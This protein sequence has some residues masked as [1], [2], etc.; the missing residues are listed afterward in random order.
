MVYMR[1][2]PRLPFE[3]ARAY[4]RRLGLRCSREFD[5]WATSSAR[6]RNIPSRP[7][8]YY[9]EEYRGMADFLGVRKPAP[10]RLRQ[11]QLPLDR[12]AAG[13]PR[14]G[15]MVE[16]PCLFGASEK[17]RC[18]EPWVVD[19]QR[20]MPEIGQSVSQ[21][22]FTSE[23][24]CAWVV[25]QL[26]EICPNLKLEKAPFQSRASFFYQFA[27]QGTEDQTNDVWL[28]LKVCFA[29]TTA[30]ASPRTQ[31]FRFNYNKG[32]IDGLPGPGIALIALQ[33]GSVAFRTGDSATSSSGTIRS[34][35]IRT[36][37]SNK[38]DRLQTSAAECGQFA[39]ENSGEPPAKRTDKSSGRERVAIF[40]QDKQMF[41]IR[42]LADT[43]ASC[44]RDLSGVHARP[45]VDWLVDLAASDR[46]NRRAMLITHL[47]HIF[48]NK[49]GKRVTFESTVGKGCD[50]YIDGKPTLHRLL[51]KV[52]DQKRRGRCVTHYR[53]KLTTTCNRKF[54]LA[55]EFVGAG[56]REIPLSQ[57]VAPKFV[58][59][60]R[61]ENSVPGALT[62]IW[63]FPR[64]MFASCLI[65]EG[66][67]TTGRTDL[68]LFTPECRPT[69]RQ[70]QRAQA[71]QMPY[72]IPVANG[73]ISDVD[74]ERARAILD[75]EFQ[76]QLYPAFVQ[77]CDEGNIAGKD[78]NGRFGEEA[79][80]RF[81]CI[82]QQRAP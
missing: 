16:S 56:Y 80:L 35:A 32:D 60:L 79:E 26:S 48:Y 53:I 18:E 19:R 41:P 37:T 81:S 49:L 10:W 73:R 65:V 29:S 12:S 68:P 74:F 47:H 43:L 59:A 39:N 14:A 27:A 3:E 15:D 44:W 63:I 21:A 70:T 45:M 23:K 38:E 62:G 24:G 1:R 58:I 78:Q 33:A 22:H 52:R 28:P 42:V 72:Y 40:I 8:K 6:P 17:Q 20:R 50:T 67:I 71:Q 55:S 13:S 54:F 69:K 9:P 5:K 2:I 66:D 82:E 64:A 4:V 76:E 75:E 57:H 36:A 34:T 7:S 61:S 31:C 11:K 51:C 30:F 77:P 46:Q 25:Q